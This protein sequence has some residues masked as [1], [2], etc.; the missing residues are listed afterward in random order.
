MNMKTYLTLAL[1]CGFTKA[2]YFTHEST[3]TNVTCPPPHL[4]MDQSYLFHTLMNAASILCANKDLLIRTMIDVM[5]NTTEFSVSTLVRSMRE[6]T[7]KPS[8]V[9]KGGIDFNL[10]TLCQYHCTVMIE[11]DLPCEYSCNATSSQNTKT[12][13][14]IKII[15]RQLV[16]K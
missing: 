11:L 5:Q 7:V 6:T 1:I 15:F 2:L 10:E 9:K 16:V 13:S 3:T 14:R 12:I 4:K 8:F